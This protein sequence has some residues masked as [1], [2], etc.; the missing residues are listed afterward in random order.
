MANEMTER[1]RRHDGYPLTPE[2]Y[3]A[4]DELVAGSPPLSREQ[5][6]DS[7]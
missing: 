3:A 4:I 5:I 2:Q 1:R 6:R 7:R